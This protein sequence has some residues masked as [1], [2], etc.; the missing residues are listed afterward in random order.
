[1]EVTGADLHRARRKSGLGPGGEVEDIG[2]NEIAVNTSS[3]AV[4][5]MTPVSDDRQSF[6]GSYCHQVGSLVVVAYLQGGRLKRKGRLE[7]P[8][9]LS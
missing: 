6:E 3:F 8:F 5:H 2:H 1:L 9:V 4:H 7:F